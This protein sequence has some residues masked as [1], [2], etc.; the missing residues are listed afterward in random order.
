MEHQPRQHPTPWLS[1]WTQPRA[2]MRRILDTS[3]RK[4]ILW[5]AIFIGALNLYGRALSN[6][7]GELFGFWGTWLTVV[8]LSPIAGAFAVMIPSLL[9]TWIGKW[10]KGAGTYKDIETAVIWSSVPYL[11]TVLLI[12]LDFILYGT[13]LFDP[14][15]TTISWEDG[16]LLF[17]L[18]WL[19]AALYEIAVIWAFVTQIICVSVAHR[20]SLWKGL[21][22]VIIPSL[23]TGL[24]GLW[25]LIRLLFQ[26]A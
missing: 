19:N 1:M 8:L 23:F 21:A 3:S 14:N 5:L 10:F 17:L 11:W 9:F 13:G 25:P 6:G 26:T 15:T 7:F 16:P 2:T 4:N 20:F 18:D 22:I 24:I 12:P